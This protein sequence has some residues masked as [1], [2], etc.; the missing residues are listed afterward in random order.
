[1]HIKF[2][3]VVVRTEAHEAYSP[4]AGTISLVREWII[5]REDGNEGIDSNSFVC[6]TLDAFEQICLIENGC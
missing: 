4:C 1:M 2:I 3:I 5:P 6:E